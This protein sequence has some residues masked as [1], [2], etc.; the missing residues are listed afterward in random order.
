[1]KLKTEESLLKRT[2]KL[3]GDA[4]IA[5]IN[6]N[7][8]DAQVQE[9]EIKTR[10]DLEALSIAK[11]RIISSI[12]SSKLRLENFEA[13]LSTPKQEIRKVRKEINKLQNELLGTDIS[14]ISILFESAKSK[15]ELAEQA[16]DAAATRFDNIAGALNSQIENLVGSQTTVVGLIADEISNFTTIV[17]LL[18]EVADIRGRTSDGSFTKDVSDASIK[19][20]KDIIKRRN[21][22]LLDGARQA[23]ELFKRQVGELGSTSSL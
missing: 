10:V 21:Q 8:K 20:Q 4:D 6:K 5:L 1:M 13:D 23:R 7:D 15:T 17:D 19:Q 11:Q 3:L 16:A 14:K 9:L 12:N 2:S 18:G 22:I